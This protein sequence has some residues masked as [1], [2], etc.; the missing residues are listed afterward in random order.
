[1][2]VLLQHYVEVLPLQSFMCPPGRFKITRAYSLYALSGRV[3]LVKQVP[4][5]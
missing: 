4:F 5:K 1:M 2:G 3:A